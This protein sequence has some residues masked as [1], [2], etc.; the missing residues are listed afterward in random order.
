MSYMTCAIMI[1]YLRDERDTYRRD[2][3]IA[4]RGFCSNDVKLN[5]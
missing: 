1:N 3:V 2:E 4:F 5:Y